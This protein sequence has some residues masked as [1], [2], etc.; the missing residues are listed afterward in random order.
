MR[1]YLEVDLPMNGAAKTSARALVRANPRRL[2]ASLPRAIARRRLLSP[3]AVIT[4]VTT[5]DFFVALS[6]SLSLSERAA[7]ATQLCASTPCTR[8][9]GGRRYPQYRATELGN[10]IDWVLEIMREQ[11]TEISQ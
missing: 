5:R 4:G 6:L 7:P 8:A 2:S 11:L 3:A 9:R 10:R 1:A